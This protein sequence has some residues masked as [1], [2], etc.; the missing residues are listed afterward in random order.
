MAQSNNRYGLM[1]KVKLMRARVQMKEQKVKEGKLRL[2]QKLAD[3]NEM[4]SELAMH[5]S[6]LDQKEIE[7]N[8]E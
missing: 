3:M 5:T 7:F 2:K 4:N 6:S 1:E 8:K